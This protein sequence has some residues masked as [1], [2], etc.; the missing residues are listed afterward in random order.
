MS[1]VAIVRGVWIATVLAT[2]ALVSES[3]LQSG[4]G[5]SMVVGQGEDAPT[6]AGIE[7]SRGYALARGEVVVTWS[8]WDAAM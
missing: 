1:T 4:T 6:D 5:T 3:L 2:S 8:T 7:A